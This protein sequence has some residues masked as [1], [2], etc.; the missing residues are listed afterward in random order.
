MPQFMAYELFD[1]IIPDFPD[2]PFLQQLGQ[3]CAAAWAA[4][5]LPAWKKRVRTAVELLMRV[6]A[7]DS[8]KLIEIVLATMESYFAPQKSSY[9]TIRDRQDKEDSEEADVRFP[10]LFQEYANK[11]E[12]VY[13]HLGTIFAFA[14]DSV[15]SNPQTVKPSSF[16][17]QL[18]AK[19]KISKLDSP[20]IIG[21]LP[22]NTLVEGYDRHFRNAI[23][24]LRYKCIDRELV[25]MWDVNDKNKETWRAKL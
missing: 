2:T 17:L 12:S 8:A 19:T 13:R 6:P 20:L 14:K 16:W 10:A 4:E 3:R 18:S 25:E 21:T 7:S 22:I 15:F 5:A 1:D 11:L 9:F 23:A 24:H